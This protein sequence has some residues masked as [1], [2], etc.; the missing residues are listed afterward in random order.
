MTTISNKLN[1][2]FLF[3]GSLFCS[4]TAF[5]QDAIFDN[6]KKINLKNQGAIKKGA[7]VTGYFFIYENNKIVSDSNI[8]KFTI[9]D[10]QLKVLSQ[11]TITV[12]NET[13]F[14]ETACNGTTIL[15]SFF[16]NK[17]KT[18]EYDIFETNGVKKFTYTRDLSRKEYKQ[19]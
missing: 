16:N 2:V 4:L 10:K 12:L 3:V 11:N 17:T 9:T 19:L 8:Y 1:L 14:F 6:V 13:K 18:Y 7:E 15:L 5:S